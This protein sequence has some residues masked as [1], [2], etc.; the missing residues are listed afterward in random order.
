MAMQ[1]K[2][3][4]FGKCEWGPK[5]ALPKIIAWVW[6]LI[7]LLARFSPSFSGPGIAE[8]RLRKKIEGTYMY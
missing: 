8:G 7:I 3:P 2:T 6:D 5:T 4:S 1:N